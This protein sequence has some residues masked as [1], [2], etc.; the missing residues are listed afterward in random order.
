MFMARDGT[1]KNSFAEIGIVA[2]LSGALIPICPAFAAVRSSCTCSDGRSLET[3]VVSYSRNGD[4]EVITRIET[5]RKAAGASCS[6]VWIGGTEIHTKG[7]PYGFY[8]QRTAQRERRIEGCG[9]VSERFV[10]RSKTYAFA[11]DS[12]STSISKMLSGSSPSIQ[13]SGSDPKLKSNA[14]LWDAIMAEDSSPR[15]RTQERFLRIDPTRAFNRTSWVFSRK[16]IHGHFVGIVKDSAQNETLI[17]LKRTRKVSAGQ[18]G[19]IEAADSRSAIVRF[20]LGS[21]VERLAGTKNAIRRW[22]DNIG[23]PYNETRDDLYTALRAYIV[24]VSLDDI[25]EVND[26][27]DQANT[28]RTHPAGL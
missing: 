22:Y 16:N 3:G 13:V 11:F 8:L 23:G 20:Y 6:A 24:E 17:P 14:N 25:I 5:E 4:R 18:L 21:G 1:P 9:D 27:L 19:Q 26:Y 10:K 28:D 2:L 12:D 7:T 15:V